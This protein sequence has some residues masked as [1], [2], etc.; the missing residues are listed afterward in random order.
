MEFHLASMENVTCWAF[1]KLF[2]GVTDSYTGVLSLNYILGK[3][4]WKEA[5]L[6]PI[7]GQRQWIQIASSKEEECKKFI[8][9]LQ[10]ECQEQPEKYNVY[11]VQLNCSCPS[12]NLIKLGH[13]PAL[14]SK[15]Q[16]VAVLLR[17]LMKQDKFKIG[18]KIRLGLTQEEVK[19]GRIFQLLS[20]LEKIKGLAHVVIHFKHAKEPS[21]TPY[22]YS[23]LKRI[24]NYNLP[25]I[26]NG[27]INS[28][29]DFLRITKDANKKNIMG[30]MMGR[31][32]LKDPNCF[33]ES[34]KILNNK[35][36]SSKSDE[37][38]KKE[39]EDNCKL[40]PPKEVYVKTIKKYC[41]WAK[42]LEIEFPKNNQPLN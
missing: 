4:N 40:H 26:I 6:F 7:Q 29:H 8:E 15:P 12:Y 3:R 13:G 42:S 21:Y 11:G 25:I 39:F 1:R 30:F 32:A 22:D 31:Q 16:K 34:S 20:E 5:D 24:S 10:R 38:V 9:R 37:Q 17:A 41:S 33:I 23:L 35:T 18:I 14:I 19:Q 27:G 36:F 2:S 28:H